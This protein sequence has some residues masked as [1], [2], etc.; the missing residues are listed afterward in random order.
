MKKATLKAKKRSFLFICLLMPYL[1]FGAQSVSDLRNGYG[2]NKTTWNSATGVLTFTASGTAKLP[3]KGNLDWLWDVPTEVKKIVINRNVTVNAGFHFSHTMTIEGKDRNTSVI[4]GTNEQSWADNRG[5]KAFTIAQIHCKS[6]VGTLKNFTILNPRAFH[7]LGNG[8]LCH[9]SYCSFIDDREGGGNHSDGYAGGNGSTIDNCYFETGDDVIKIY[10]D[11]T[12]TNTHIH[13]VQNCVPIQCGWGNTG[14]NTATFQNLTITGTKGRGNDSF[15]VIVARSGKY[16]K[17]INIDGCNIQN[18]NASWASLRENGQVIKGTVTNALIDIKQYWG[19]SNGA[20]QMNICGTTQKKN[21]YNCSGSTPPPA[22]IPIPGTVE[23]EDF[24]SQSGIQTESCSEGGLNVGWTD[25]GDWMDY[26]VDVDKAGEYKV[27]FR[28]AALNSNISFNL[29]KGSTTLTNVNSAATGGWQTWK[30]VSRT[31]TLSAGKQT[32]RVQATGGGW[33]INWM[34]FTEETSTTPP[35]GDA[36]IGKTISLKGNNNSYVS[37]ENGVNAMVCN[38]TAVGAWEKFTVVNAGNGKVALQGNNGKYV[39]DGS[40]MWC[41]SNTITNAAKFTWTN[42]GGGLIALKGNNGNYVSSENGLQA[43]N[44]NRSAIGA[45][46]KFS[47]AE[48]AK[49]VVKRSDV[50]FTMYPNPANTSVTISLSG[51]ENATVSIYSISGALMK[52]QSISNETINVSLDNIPSGT[53]F[54]QLRS[55]TNSLIEKLIVE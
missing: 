35:T 14:D 51:A 34:K 40:P 7:V 44:C 53:Y 11:I 27:E 45:W 30:T 15:A 19:Y 21:Y 49:S 1:V 39:T 6:G 16:T 17:T 13:M 32:L 42:A 20:S 37:S 5:I 47:W 3:G 28:V 33:N 25:N 12:V 9:I 46:E 43:M 52:A 2:T 50:E 24:S 8:G 4:F 36:P 26:D 29:K 31:V 10:E 23:A 18:P 55:G 38:R 22:D 41:S 48:V 54:V